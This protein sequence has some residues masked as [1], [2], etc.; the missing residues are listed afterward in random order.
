MVEILVQTRIFSNIKKAKRVSV[1]NFNYIHYHLHLGIFHMNI[2][3]EK[4]F[5]ATYFVLFF[6][7]TTILPEAFFFGQ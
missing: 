2:N 5:L 3:K 1:K 6:S 4:V 7:S